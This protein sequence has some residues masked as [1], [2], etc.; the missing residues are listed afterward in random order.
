MMLAHTPAGPLAS[1]VS[2]IGHAEG[3]HPHARE[4]A[5][6]TGGSQLLVNLD[7]DRLSSESGGV[8]TVVSGAGLSGAT[9][10]P[11]VIDPAEQRA[12]M[13]VC[14][15][16]GAAAALFD[17][18]AGEFRDALVPLAELWGST[19][20][21]LRERLLAE[22]TPAARIELL[23]RVLL[24]RAARGREPEPG[25]ARAAVDLHRGVAVATVADRLGWTDRRLVRSFTDQIGLPPKRFARVRRFQ[26]LLGLR[27][28]D[29][30]D[31]AG[32]AAEAGYYDQ[33]HMI[34][35]FRE[36]T[37]MSPTSYAPRSPGERN[38]VP[39]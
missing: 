36:F 9:S 20:A 33:A 1:L 6:P 29:A 14:L 30:S 28:G 22:P 8:R 27:C 23:E 12:V 34:H 18:P 25:V 31:W 35:D 7:A 3:S 11:A 4:L 17:P 13:W 24:G 37:G 26:R 21:A 38:H 15:R 32:R 5:L 16:P 2:S 39:L 10:R 19:G